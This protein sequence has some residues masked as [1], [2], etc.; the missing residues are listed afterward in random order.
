MVAVLSFGADAPFAVDS[1]SLTD[2]A[3]YTRLTVSTN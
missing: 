3:G 1:L 2:V